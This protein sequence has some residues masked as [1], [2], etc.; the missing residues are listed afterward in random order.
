MVYR[1]IRRKEEFR[2]GCTAAAQDVCV[3][4][5]IIKEV[6]GECVNKYKDDEPFR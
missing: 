1:A 3:Q 6:Q 4:E 2:N 5:N